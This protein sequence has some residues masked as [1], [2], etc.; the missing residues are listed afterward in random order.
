MVVDDDDR[1]RGLARRML[2]GCGYRAESEARSVA[3]ALHQASDHMPDLVLIDVG[4][5][6]GDGIQLTKRLTEHCSA[7]RVVLVSADCDAAS[8]RD[9]KDAG[10]VGFVAKSDLNCAVLHLLL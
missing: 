1:F 9:A 7:T 8:Q 10:A 2:D 3:D 5:P 4:L 6:D